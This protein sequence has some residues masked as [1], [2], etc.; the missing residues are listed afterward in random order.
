MQSD[1]NALADRLFC[2]LRFFFVSF[3]RTVDANCAMAECDA[4]NKS[5]H[6]TQKTSTRRNTK[7]RRLNNTKRSS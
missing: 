7:T 5:V 4:N 3:L 6:H 1:L 2:E